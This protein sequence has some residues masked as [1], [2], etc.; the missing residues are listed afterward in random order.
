MCIIKIYNL[1]AIN[2]A[3]VVILSISRLDAHC[4][5]VSSIPYG[6]RNKIGLSYSK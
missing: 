1:P 3:D 2:K 4:V 6:H 5:S